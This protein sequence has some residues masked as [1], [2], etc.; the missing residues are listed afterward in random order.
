[1]RAALALPE[2]PPEGPL[3]DALSAVLCQ[4]IASDVAYDAGCA[5]G[6]G[7]RSVALAGNDMCVLGA[8]H[9]FNRPLCCTALWGMPCVPGFACQLATMPAKTAWRS[10]CPS[11]CSWDHQ[12][13]M[14]YEYWDN[15]WESEDNEEASGG[16]LAWWSGWGAAAG[17]GIPF[18][19][20]P[21]AMQCA[22]Q[23]IRC[24]TP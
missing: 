12:F 19:G 21:V 13:G 4:G 18:F 7:D 9:Y 10:G 22:S 2:A 1:M 23:P 15:A 11:V 5:S 8:A 16:Y 6:E 3:R 14:A 20:L 24:N 17:T